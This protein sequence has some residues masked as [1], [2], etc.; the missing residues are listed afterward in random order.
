M[1]PRRLDDV[2][3]VIPTIGRSS[4]HR[5]LV[6]LSKQPVPVARVVVV[7]D[8]RRPDR[9]VLVPAALV[10]RTTVLAAGGRGPAAARNVGW[11]A[12]DSPWVVFL[13]DDVVPSPTWAVQLGD[14][15]AVEVDVA[16]TQGRIVVPVPT[17]RRPTDRERNVARLEAAEWITADM[18]VRRT[19]LEH[20]AGFDERFRR[21]Y[22]ED[23]DFA[24]RLA[25]RG[26]R[27]QHGA[28]RSTHPVQPARWWA[29]VSA[30]RGNRDDALMLALHG[31][32]WRSDRGRRGRHT[33][34][35]A[36]G[37][38]AAVL[39]GRGHR[40]LAALAGGVWLGGTAEFAAHRIARGPRRLPEITAMLLTSVL[41]PP[42]AAAYWASGR[43]AHRP[44]R[45]HRW[46]QP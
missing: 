24:L 20:V 27:L 29:S 19:A 22:R 1:A 14:D 17:E 30:Q 23:T 35:T 36:A 25:Q 32:G 2:S 5:L 34:I 33:V 46:A 9:D 15:L 31:R 11:R 10:A 6:A 7:D 4:L 42:T 28:R 40:G 38:S 44:A 13:D 26:W 45:T 43:I 12:T 18:A 21:A 39:A 37:L 16:A 3:V 41:I 8:R